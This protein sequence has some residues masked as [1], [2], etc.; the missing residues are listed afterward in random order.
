MWR[1]GS[2]LVLAIRDQIAL[3]A[4]HH[5]NSGEGCNH[6]VPNLTR[7]M[8]IDCVLSNSFGFRRH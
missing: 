8:K 4:I 6:Y 2:V 3:P 7:P 1:S 5:E